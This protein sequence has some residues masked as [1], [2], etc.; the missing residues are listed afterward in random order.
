MTKLLFSFSQENKPKKKFIDLFVAKMFI[1]LFVAGGK[2][3]IY[4]KFDSKDS[5]HQ[6]LVSNESC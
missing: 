4:F 2:H 5:A 3:L 1:D 6:Q